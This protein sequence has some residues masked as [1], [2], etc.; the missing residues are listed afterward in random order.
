MT[1]RVNRLTV[2]LDGD[3]RDDDLDQLIGAIRLMRG[4][5]KVKMHV[6]DTNDYL[7]VERAK[8]DLREKI[9]DLV[10]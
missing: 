4:V 3:Y 1:D 9:L 8:A 7:A 10:R 5:L 6:A 2:I